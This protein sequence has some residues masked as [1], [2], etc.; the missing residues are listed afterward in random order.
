MMGPGI[1]RA[2]Q[3]PAKVWV[4]IKL[5]GAEMA[6]LARLSAKMQ[7]TTDVQTIRAALVRLAQDLGVEVGLRPCEMP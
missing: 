2:R 7:S 5:T 3:R 1:A 6:L 4:R